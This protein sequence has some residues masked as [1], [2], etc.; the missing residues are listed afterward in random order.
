MPDEAALGSCVCAAAKPVALIDE[1]DEGSSSNA[2]SALGWA[3]TCVERDGSMRSWVKME[4]LY[5]HEPPSVMMLWSVSLLLLRHLETAFAPG[6]W[7]G[8]RVLELGAGAGHLAVGL[9][10]LGAH[11]VATESG[12]FNGGAAY[13]DMVRWARLLLAERAG[14]GEEVAAPESPGDAAQCYS[15]GPGGDGGTVSF[16]KLHW[17]VDDAADPASWSGFDTLVVADALYDEEAHEPL[18]ASL[19]IVLRPGMTA[20]SAFVDRPFSLAFLALLDDDG[21]FEVEDVEL[22]DRCALREDEIVYAHRITRRVPAAASGQGLA[23]DG[24]R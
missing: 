11:V 24:T 23:L 14:G 12:E 10:R 1:N 7:R 8:K 13:T 6:S 2:S 21:S 5:P 20:Y 3:A 4:R 19:R 18:L 22:A 15:A 17:G 16:R 9:A